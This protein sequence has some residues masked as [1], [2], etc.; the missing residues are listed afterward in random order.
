MA[1]LAQGMQCISA[2]DCLDEKAFTMKS[3]A[4]TL[5]RVFC[6]LEFA[7]VENLR[8][9]NNLLDRH[10][11]LQKNPPPPTSRSGEDSQDVRACNVYYLPA[12]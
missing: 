10:D 12:R 8:D 1:K 11:G 5:R 7:N 3:L 6:A 2:A 4:L 9:L